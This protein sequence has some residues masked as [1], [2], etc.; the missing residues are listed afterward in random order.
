MTTRER[1]V[2]EAGD[3]VAGLAQPDRGLGDRPAAQAVAD[4]D[5]VPRGAG[6]RRAVDAAGQAAGVAVGA[7]GGEHRHAAAVAQR[8]RRRASSRAAATRSS[9]PLAADPPPPGDGLRADR[10]PSR[11]GRSRRTCSRARCC[12]GRRARCCRPRSSAARQAA[13]VGCRR[14]RV[15]VTTSS[16]RTVGHRA[17]CRHS[18]APPRGT[19]RAGAAVLEPPRRPGTS[20][21]RAWPWPT[22]SATPSGFARTVSVMRAPRSG[23]RQPATVPVG[24]AEATDGASSTAAQTSQRTQD[25]ARTSYPSEHD[26]PGFDRHKL[27]FLHI[28]A[29]SSGRRPRPAPARARAGTGAGARKWA[30]GIADSRARAGRH[31][32]APRRRSRASRRPSR[33]APAAPRGPAR[34]AGA[35]C[36]ARRRGSRCPCCGA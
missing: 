8:L 13:G 4:L 26:S 36:R 9:G 19:A 1:A 28:S 31:R 34:S 20:R 10:S 14:R 2:G 29:A 35:R 18:R 15:I 30:P 22:R 5:L 23:L 27:R 21:R 6:R 33:R 17:W 3:D 7:A 32:S 12:T 24:A 25:P 11:S 16:L